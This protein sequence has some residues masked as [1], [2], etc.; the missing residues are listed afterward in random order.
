MK[1]VDG[2]GNIVGFYGIYRLTKIGKNAARSGEFSIITC[3]R[4]YLRS[5][6]KH[7]Y[8]NV[9]LGGVYGK[10][11]LSRGMVVGAINQELYRTKT[12]QIFARAATDDGLRLLRNQG[13][14]PVDPTKRG[15][16]EMFSRNGY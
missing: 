12:K 9:Y 13:F 14:E 2:N 5:D 11:K 15:L 10:N 16:G 7:K 6:G 8:A 4:E 3:P 1:V